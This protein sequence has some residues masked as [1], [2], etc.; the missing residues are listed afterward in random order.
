MHGVGFRE[1]T[2]EPHWWCPG[3]TPGFRN[4]REHGSTAPRKRSR[5]AEKNRRILLKDPQ[6]KKRG[7]RMLILVLNMAKAYRSFRGLCPWTPAKGFTTSRVRMVPPCNFVAFC[8]IS[9]YHNLKTNK[10]KFYL[11]VHRSIHFRKGIS[12]GIYLNRQIFFFFF[13]SFFFF[14]RNRQ[15]VFFTFF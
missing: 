3:A 2:Q 12:K 1:P 6:K 7:I 4:P 5:T 9:F 13:F 14:F 8:E 11:L 15:K 10:V